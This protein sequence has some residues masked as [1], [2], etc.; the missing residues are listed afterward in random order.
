M[1]AR[2]EKSESGYI[3]R[4]R[5]QLNR[6]DDTEHEQALVRVII[7]VL[8]SVYLIIQ[9]YV[10]NYISHAW[11]GVQILF[12]LSLFSTG[13][14]A[15][16]IMSPASSRGRR[17]LGMLADYGVTSYLMYYYGEI[18]A[19]GYVLYLWITTGNGLRYGQQY[20]YIAML[21]SL[22][23]FFFVLNNN[24]Y[25]L[26]NQTVGYGLLMG[27]ILMPLYI[28]ALLGKLTRA[29]AE[30]EFAN[31]AKS[32]FLANMSHEIRTPMNGVIGMIDLLL[33]TP[34]D[35]EQN[36]FAKTIRT[37]ARNLLVLIDDILDISKIESGKLVLQEVNFD[38]HALLNSTIT[39]LKPQSDQ[40]GVSLKTH[41]DPHTP[42]ML[43]GDD[44]HLRQVMIN[45][46]GNA[47]KFTHE[48]SIDVIARCVHED[49]SNATIYFEI[50]D[51]GIGMSEEAQVKIFDGFTQAD[52]TITRE[53]G[54][55]GLGTTISKQLVELMGGNLVLE[56]K[57]GEGTSMSFSLP[58]KKQVYAHDI[59]KLSGK[60]L[61]ISRDLELV[62]NLNEWFAGWGLRA[63]YQQDILDPSNK[64]DILSNDHNH[65]ILVDEHCL[66]SPLE[67]AKEFSQHTQAARDGLI[68]IRRK[69][70]PSTQALLESGYSSVITLPVEQSILFNAL[71]VLYTQLPSDDQAI[72]FSFYTNK[73]IRRSEGNV[74]DILVVEDNV[75]N[76]EVIRAILK[77]AGHKV[78]VADDGEKALDYLEEHDFDI[79]ITDMHMPGKSGLEVIKLH[80]FTHQRSAEMPFVILSADISKDAEA[81]S[82]E[83]GAAKYLTK[84]VE[85]HR[86][87]HVID[88]L[89]LQYAIEK[90]NDNHDFSRSINVSTTGDNVS[91]ARL[92]FIQ[93]IDSDPDFVMK[94][95]QVFLEDGGELLKKINI[96]WSQQNI[97]ELLEA[98]HTLKG[99][100]ANIGADTVA[101][102][103]QQIMDCIRN[104]NKKPVCQQ[105]LLDLNSLFEKS[106]AE[107][108]EFLDD[109]AKKTG[110]R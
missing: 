44:V 27:L 103:S 3:S 92:E 67:F 28:A 41:I 48:G 50:R 110:S 56:S 52:N 53:Y 76:Q 24:E 20:L 40:K 22:I 5:K 74:L 58:F 33:D 18:M 75:I 95:I 109:L 85:P 72:P 39:M 70:E 23:G 73:D 80:R 11:H 63:T 4:I 15:S 94:M 100:A 25:W 59:K 9:C 91:R 87:L 105:Y 90:E 12:F 26:S 69:A 49:K 14:V 37:S 106:H 89:T 54:G 84:P 81:Q 99:C 42:Y 77:K 34:L 61:V 60:I 8:L 96:S 107:M 82:E 64:S 2:G 43:L 83:V 31:K 88:Q 16:T 13:I 7:S 62:N 17:I 47:I 68:L 6:R 71:H 36:H 86:L 102:V 55:T 35:K 1:S 51:S 19:P 30:A 45:L 93:A 101:G 108:L 66:A 21:H 32:Q 98:T 46:V 78:T 29:K 104:E 10:H 57:L 79:C 38:L 97:D 65:I